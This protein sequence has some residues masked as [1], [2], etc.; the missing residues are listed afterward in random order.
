MT[1]TVHVTGVEDNIVTIHPKTH[2]YVMLT[3]VDVKHGLIKYGEKGNE[4]VLKEL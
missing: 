4:A 3:L 1:Q 2:V